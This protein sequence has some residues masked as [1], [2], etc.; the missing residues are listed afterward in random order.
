M[1]ATAY[2]VVPSGIGTGDFGTRVFLNWAEGSQPTTIILAFAEGP[3]EPGGMNVEM[4]WLAPTHLELTYR[5]HRNLD[6]QAVKCHGIDISVR[7]LPGGTSNA[8]PR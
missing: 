8:S 2:T 6:F 4:T 3:D 5:G 1:I 7:E